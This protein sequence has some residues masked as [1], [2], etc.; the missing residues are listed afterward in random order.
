MKRISCIIASLFV[1]VTLVTGCSDKGTLMTDKEKVLSILNDRYETEFSYKGYQ[2]NQQRYAEIYVEARNL[3]EYLIVAHVEVDTLGELQVRDNY[4]SYYYIHEIAEKVKEAARYAFGTNVL[5]KM[6]VL[7][8]ALD[9]VYTKDAA[10][11]DIIHDSSKLYLCD[12]AIEN[13][14]GDLW[15]ARDRDMDAFVNK[16]K[17][18]GISMNGSIYYLSSDDYSCFK[19]ENFSDESNWNWNDGVGT[20]EMDGEKSAIKWY[21]VQ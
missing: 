20:F 3:P 10:F 2:E 4:M 16:L 6:R 13:A 1:M 14:T 11:E 15:E 17:E 7:R 21:P 18:A 19:E 8:H 12:I 5:V 9:N